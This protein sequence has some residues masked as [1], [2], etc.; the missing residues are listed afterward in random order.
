MTMSETEI[1]FEVRGT[2]GLVTLNRPRAVNALTGSMV[3][4]MLRTLTVWASDPA[5][6]QVLVHGAGDRGLCAGGDIVAIH[7]DILVGGQSTANFWQT[8]YRLN[9][10][11]SSYPKPYIAYMDGLVLG[12]GVGISAHGSHR[13]VT[14]R[15]RSGMP[16][17]TIGFCPDVGGTYL[18]SRSPGRSGIHAALTGDHLG[19]AEVIYLGLADYLIDSARFP[20]LLE[21]LQEHPVEQVLPRFVLPKPVANLEA[22]GEWIDVAYARPTV[23]EIIAKLHEFGISGNIQAQKT[24]E[25]LAK[26]S[27]TALAVTLESLHRAG[28]LESLEAVLEQEYRVGLHFLAS[29]DFPEGI[30]AQVIDKD[31]APVW[32][33]ATLHEVTPETV[34]AF[35]APLGEHE[36]HLS[37]SASAA[38]TIES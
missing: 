10:L 27:P 21:R 6:A 3:E 29:E 34:A 33:P 17:T 8:E 25:T 24:M 5:I 18:L 4:A 26:K 20:Q 11:I 22:W 32:N 9:A 31:Y 1:I 30:R 2:L 38:Q 15:T 12:G 13:I 35:F 14:E 28:N 36:L 16:E 37:P 7:R 23:P 19:G